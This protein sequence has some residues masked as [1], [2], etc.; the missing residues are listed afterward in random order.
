MH[1]QTFTSQA[2]PKKVRNPIR[3][4]HIPT[5]KFFLR[6]RKLFHNQKFETVIED[7]LREQTRVRNHQKLQ[8]KVWNCRQIRSKPIS[9]RELHL[10]PIP[11]KSETRSDLPTGKFFLRPRKLFHNQKFETVIEDWLREQTRVRNHQKLQSKVWNCPTMAKPE[12][13]TTKNFSIKIL[14]LS[15]SGKY[16]GD[17][18]REQTRVRKHQKNIHNQKTMANKVGGGLVPIT[19]QSQQSIVWNCPRIGQKPPKL[20]ITP[21]LAN[22][23]K[24]NL[25]AQT[26]RVNLG[27]S[28]TPSIL[29]EILGQILLKR[30]LGEFIPRNNQML[31]LDDVID[32]LFKLLPIPGKSDTWSAVSNSKSPSFSQTTNNFF[33]YF[34]TPR[35]DL[36]FDQNCPSILETC[37]PFQLWWILAC[38][39]QIQ[40][41]LFPNFTIPILAFSSLVTSWFFITIQRIFFSQN[42]NPQT[43][44]WHL[45]NLITPAALCRNKSSRAVEM[46][47]VADKNPISL[48][49]VT[50]W[51]SFQ[52]FLKGSKAKT[53][54]SPLTSLRLRKNYKKLEI[55][56][57]FTM[58]NK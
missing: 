53:W 52:N 31:Q 15:N 20:F 36:I 57:H 24:A 11:R 43:I 1:W 22:Q 27:P 48:D 10:R 9:W 13:E 50:H 18:L 55:P 35:T 56:R 38:S 21:T 12:S 34:Q 33:N 30:L 16:W 58:K 41:G 40:N 6:P 17:W 14:K 8:S 45:G 19:D 51:P 37:S 5:G 2:N 32:R 54:K 28:P 25:L 7:W 29:S 4:N 23:L 26:P 3:P 44:R 39:F 46:L 42:F 47:T 49:D